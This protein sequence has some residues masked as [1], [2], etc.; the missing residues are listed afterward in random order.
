M[1]H[2]VSQTHQVVEVPVFRVI[3]QVA[4]LFSPTFD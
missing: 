4:P 1:S 2:C 3:E